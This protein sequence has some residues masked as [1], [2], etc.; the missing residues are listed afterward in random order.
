M[1]K[2][3]IIKLGVSAHY[4]LCFAGSRVAQ[5]CGSGALY[6]SLIDECIPST[7]VSNPKF[8]NSFMNDIPCYGGVVETTARL[9]ALRYC[10]TII[11]GGLTLTVND[12]LADFSALFD[13]KTITGI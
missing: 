7:I 4:S 5:D 12:P 11:E 1:S 3:C 9:E 6:Y 8:L 13:I 2:E 10:N